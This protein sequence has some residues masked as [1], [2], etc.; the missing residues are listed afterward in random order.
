MNVRVVVTLLAALAVSSG[1]ATKQ[2]LTITSEPSGANIIMVR[3]VEKTKH[4]DAAGITT[5]E[6]VEIIEETPEQLGM[7]PIEEHKFKPFWTGWVRAGLYK[8]QLTKHCKSAKIVAEKDGL[9]A[10]TVVSFNQDHD[11]VTVHLQLEPRKPA[12]APSRV[13]ESAEPK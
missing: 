6:N 1:C 4:Q 5:K 12:K 10:E 7:T 11:P 13:V 2:A 8:W 3:I 9:Y